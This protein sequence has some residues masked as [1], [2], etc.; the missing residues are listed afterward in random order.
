VGSG[1]AEEIGEL[2]GLNLNIYQTLK[3]G[4]SLCESRPL[5]TSA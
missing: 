3:G 1:E 2:P 4:L 5:T